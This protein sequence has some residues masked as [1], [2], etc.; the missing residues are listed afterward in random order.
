MNLLLFDFWGTL[1][2]LEEGRDFIAEIASLLDITK[3]EYKEFVVERG[4]KEGLSPEEFAVKLSD[5][6]GKSPTT[7]LVTLLSTPIERV[8]LYPDVVQNLNRLAEGYRLALVSDTT[9]IGKECASR[10][11]MERYFGNMFFSCDY[12]I[13]K[14]EGLYKL[15]IMELGIEPSNCTVIGN[16]MNSDYLMAQK[17]GSQAIL[18]DRRNQHDG[19]R[20][21]ITLEELK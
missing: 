2:Y 8:K 5:H 4:Y 17:M 6:F 9:K 21:V 20:K 7:N 15:A 10:T 14:K 11:K 16:S 1:A 13:T 3:S 18:I 12:G 19:V